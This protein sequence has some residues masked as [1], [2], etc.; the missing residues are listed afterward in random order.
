MIKFSIGNT[1]LHA[2]TCINYLKGFL[3]IFYDE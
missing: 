3:N 1:I 2:K